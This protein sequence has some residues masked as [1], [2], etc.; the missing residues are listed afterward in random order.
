MEKYIYKCPKC[1]NTEYFIEEG[2]ASVRKKI[3][4]SESE[5]GIFCDEED[6]EAGEILSP[7]VT[8]AKCGSPD[9]IF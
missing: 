7:K 1:G 2:L 3:R 5:K 6:V 4:F 9:V 8:C